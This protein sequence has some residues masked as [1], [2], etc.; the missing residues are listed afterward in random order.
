[1]NIREMHYDFKQKINKIDSQKYRNL[2]IPEIDWKLNEAINVFVKIIAEPRLRN[3]LG[4]EINQRT[5]DDIRTLV[6]NQSFKLSNCVTTVAYDDMSFLAE[7]PEDYLFY[8]S[9]SVSATK[10]NCKN[11][12]IRTKLRQHDDEHEESLFDSSSFEWREVNMRFFEKG[13]RLFTDG[14]FNIE[15]WCVNYIRKPVF[16]HNA[17]QYI[18]NTYNLL[19]GTALTGSQSCDLPEHTHREIVDLAVLIATGDMQIPDYNVK[20]AK[21]KLTN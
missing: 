6:I 5:I 13:V 10:G 15:A 3:N 7:L 2:R 17:E 19:D 14:T 16:V 1:M 9:S 20:Q 11:V 21:I 8:V 12:N 18:N 4:F